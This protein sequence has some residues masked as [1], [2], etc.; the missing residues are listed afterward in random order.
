MFQPLV[1]TAIGEVL[2]TAR[3]PQHSSS[4]PAGWVVLL[5]LMVLALIIAGV[6]KGCEDDEPAAGPV[7]TTTGTGTTDTGQTG[8]GDAQGQTVIA[9][10][11]RVIEAAGGIQ[12]ATGETTL[13]PAAEKILD[14]VANILARNVDVKAEVGG[15][16]DTQGDAAKNQQLS[17]QRAQA[18]VKY[19]NDKGIPSAN[20]K[21][22]GYGSQQPLEPNDTTEELRA[23]NRRVEFKLMS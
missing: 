3:E 16:T 18:V 14:D 13:T 20:L 12:F 19:L 11:N 5:A 1:P 8:T 4:G 17:Q 2:T 22:V 23:K 9:E 10:I 21:A 15:H 7:T 6:A